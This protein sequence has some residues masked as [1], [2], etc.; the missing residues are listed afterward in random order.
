M[1]F[2][3]VEW[4]THPV[5]GKGFAADVDGNW[6]SFLQARKGGYRGDHSHPVDQFTVLL[7]GEAMV[8]KEIEGELVE[9]PLKP[10]KVHVTPAG[11]THILIPITDSVLYE[12]WDGPFIAEPC[13]GVFDEYKEG[14]VGPQD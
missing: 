4:G 2:E 13:P 8:V 5:V 3:L 14:R 10:N 7:G 11:I 9:I 6:C 1:K 12:W